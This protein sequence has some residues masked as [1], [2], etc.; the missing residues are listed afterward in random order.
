MYVVSNLKDVLITYNENPYQTAMD[1]Y[2][3]TSKIIKK[4]VFN[5]TEKRYYTVTNY[6]YTHNVVI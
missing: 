5:N 1:I 2:I 6:T 3:S 4:K